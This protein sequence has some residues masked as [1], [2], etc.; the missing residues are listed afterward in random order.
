MIARLAPLS[1]GFPR[2]E[3]W[4]GLP[5]PSPGDL[6]Y[7][8]IEPRSPALQAES[9]PSEPP[10]SLWLCPFLSSYS[11]IDFLC[12][13]VHMVKKKKKS[14]LQYSCLE[15]S[16]DRGAWGC[17][18]SDSTQQLTAH[19]HTH[20]HTIICLAWLF[21][22]FCIFLLLWLN[23]FFGTWGRPRRLHFFFPTKKKQTEEMAGGSLSALCH[24]KI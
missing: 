7:P 9:L 23:I 1:M 15:N 8:G 18:E 22:W 2:Q 3:Y 19:T 13:P 16:M 5:F 17:K 14:T 20:T 11:I 10:T 24:V 6:P 21:L 12:S 4:S